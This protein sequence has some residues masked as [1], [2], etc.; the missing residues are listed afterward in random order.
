M[1]TRPMTLYL[2]EKYA[3]VPKIGV[4]VGVEKGENA[5]SLLRELNM[6]CLWLVDLWAPYHQSGK[7]KS[8]VVDKHLDYQRVVKNFGGKSNVRIVKGESTEIATWFEDKSLDFVYIDACHNY[9][10]VREDIIAWYPKVKPGGV[11]GGHDY[12]WDGVQ[13][14]VDKAFPVGFQLAEGDWWF[15]MGVL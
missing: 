8:I 12:D 15:E 6:E 11:L 14:A 2:K 3:G 4:E 1:R 5:E 7:V 10:N 9:E 13:R